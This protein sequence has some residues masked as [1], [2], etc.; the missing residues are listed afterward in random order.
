[1]PWS[2]GSLPRCLSGGAVGG[3]LVSE[4]AGEEDPRREERLPLASYQALV[5]WVSMAWTY[6]PVEGVSR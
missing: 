2:P 1:M 3:V 6:S 5:L 4:K